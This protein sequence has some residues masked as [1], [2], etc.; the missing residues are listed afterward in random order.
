MLCCSLREE[1]IFTLGHIHL[2]VALE[3]S[4]SWHL[5]TFRLFLDS[6]LLLLQS[7]PSH[8]AWLFHSAPWY[9]RFGVDRRQAR[10]PGSSEQSDL[11]SSQT[12]LV[13]TQ[14]QQCFPLT[15][16][17]GRRPLLTLALLRMY[18]HRSQATDNPRFSRFTSPPCP[19]NMFWFLIN[20]TVMVKLCW[21]VT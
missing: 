10:Q 20:E 5:N 4:V 13:K 18:Y 15:S 6:C 3:L 2:S 21:V 12:A 8:P 19:E 14:H 1:T 16:L 7:S 9:L 11:W 17:S